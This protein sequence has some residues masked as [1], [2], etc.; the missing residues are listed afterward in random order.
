M[1][2][3][4]RTYFKDVFRYLCKLAGDEQVAEDLTAD[5]FYRAFRSID[6]FRGECDARLWLL[7]IAKN[8]YYTHCRRN[9]HKAVSPEAAEDL[10]DPVAPI[11][12]ELAQKEQTEQIR[13]LLHELSEPY[14]EIFMWRVYGDLS[15]REIGA[16][17]GRSENWACVTYHRAAKMIRARLEEKL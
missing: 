9:R 4:Y 5:T 8:C 7:R 11:E 10:P 15:F 13:R 2:E 6:D 1:D 17:F 12:E 14:K 16:M 3:L